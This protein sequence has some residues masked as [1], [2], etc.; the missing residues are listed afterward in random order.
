MSLRLN[1]FGISTKVSAFLCLGILL[2]G[3]SGAWG[4]TSTAGTVA[5]VVTDQQGAAI[6]GAAVRLTDTSTNEV[7]NSVTNIDGRYAF[8]SVTPGKYN[9]SFG[10][11][12]FTSYRVD[13]QAVDVGQSLTIN[14]TL[15]VGSTTMTVEVSASA[16]AQLQTMNATVGNTLAG[17]S[18]LMLPNMGRDATSL[19]VL[20]P[21][22]SPSGFTAGSY[23][24]ANTYQLDGASITDDMAGNTIG[25]QT[26]YSGL[27]GSQGGSIPSGVIPTPIESIEEF[28]VSVSNQ[29]SDFNNS[30]GAQIQMVTKR[31]TNQFHGAAYGWYFDTK[32]GSANSWSNNHT[33][34]TFGSFSLP[35]TP[36][37]S[38]HRDRFGGAI[39][40]P[41]T[42]K[43]FLGK[44]WYFFFNYEGM[45]FPNV[46]L[47]SKN[48]PTALFK[49]GVIQVPN[50]AGTYIAYN[51]N[52]NAVTV[53]G[54]TYQPAMCPGGPCD[55]RGIGINPVVA[56]IW[57]TQMPAPN[58]PLGG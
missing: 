18:L 1:C 34:F 6:P 27:G 19:A 37:I 32:V 33:P 38:N 5:G 42:N 22:T 7:H 58:N 39:G 3:A 14:A 50:A 47:Y 25:Y 43:E 24:D 54:V 13:G 31:G 46:N 44:Q 55:P 52:P 15:N 51:L 8:T 35:Y 23:Q 30:S 41:I 56:Q 48:V 11:D 10:K 17:Q 16:G 57:N 2:L 49:A 20:Q 21:A 28:K 45:R 36:I 12:G 29:T 9:M 26:N 40:G 4:Q 53:N